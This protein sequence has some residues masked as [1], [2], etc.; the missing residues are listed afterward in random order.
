MAKPATLTATAME[1]GPT[2]LGANTV[3]VEAVVARTWS[4]LLP[5]QVGAISAVGDAFSKKS[6]DADLDAC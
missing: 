2:V 4:W 5:H 6:D 1:D 3:T